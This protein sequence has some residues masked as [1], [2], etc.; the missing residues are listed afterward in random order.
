M[1]GTLLFSAAAAARQQT[2]AQAHALATV[3]DE[4]AIGVGLGLGFIGSGRL[5]GLGGLSVV[6]YRDAFAVRGELTVSLHLDPGRRSGVSPYAAAGAAFLGTPDGA[7]EYVVFV[8]GVEAAPRIRRRWFIE[9]GL[10]GGIR[11]A[12]GLRWRPPVLR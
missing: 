8:I 11:T 9:V 6:R 1:A 3:A 7:K 12:V 4:S 2:V 5:G 10:G